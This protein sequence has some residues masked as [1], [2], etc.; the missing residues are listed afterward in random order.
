MCPGSSHLWIHCHSCALRQA[1]LP[2]SQT[3]LHLHLLRC[4]SLGALCHFPES[5]FLPCSE[6]EVKPALEKNVLMAAPSDPTDFPLITPLP[7]SLTLL[8]VPEKGA[9]WGWGAATRMPPSSPIW[10][11]SSV[12]PLPTSLVPH[13]YHGH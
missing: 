9:E 7:T 8:G 2:L 10:G 6:V 1:I 13:I 3:R 4:A 5:H 12:K 11:D